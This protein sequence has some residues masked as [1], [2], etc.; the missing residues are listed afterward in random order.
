V[1][2]DEHTPHGSPQNGHEAGAAVLVDTSW[3]LPRMRTMPRAFWRVR[4]LDRG[5][6]GSP[7][8]LW[9]HRWISRRSLLLTSIWEDQPAAQA[10][11]NSPAFQAV[12][13]QLRAH[14]GANATVRIAI[15][16]TS[17]GGSLPLRG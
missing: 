7:G 3:H 11:L 8:L 10:W 9:M 4:T 12:D 6:R 15:L 16:T 2:A 17:E 14:H 1:T 13:R 5:S